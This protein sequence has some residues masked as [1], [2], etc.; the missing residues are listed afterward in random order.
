MAKRSVREGTVFGMRPAVGRWGFVAL[1]LTINLCLG[2]VY[3]F[4]V[5][6]TPLRDL[7]GIS[8]TASG[9]LFMV[10]LAMFAV[11]M[12][13]TGPFLARHG[14]RRVSLVGG[15]LVGLGWLL[16][17]FSP[18]IGVLTLFYGGVAGGG[19]GVLYGCPIATS[20][21]WFPDRRGL[22]VGL[23]VLGF[24]V[25]PLVTAPLLA[26]SIAQLGVLPTFT[27]F[28]ALFLTLLVFLALPLRFPPPGWAP[29]G[30]VPTAKQ[31]ARAG[32]ELDRA[33]IVRTV[34]FYALWGGFTLGSVAGLMA[35]SLSKDFGV[36]V[37]G[38]GAGLA[39]L[40]VSLFAVFNGAGRPAFGWLIDRTTPRFAAAVSFTLILLA[41]AGLYGWGEGSLAV[42]LVAFSV[43]WLNLGGWVAMAP[44]S[45]AALFGPRHYPRNFALVFSG[46]GVG[47]IG[48][49]LLSG[50]IRDATGSYLPVFLPVMGLAALGIA[51]SVLG[52]RPVRPPLSAG[53][54]PGS[55]RAAAR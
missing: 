8:A 49:T 52:L 29:A 38:A 50:A 25:S 11:G 17:G 1:G 30:W 54:A 18:N 10:F 36:E 55:G 15:A 19:V 46:Y 31:R 32:I 53:T 37:A 16:A 35:V 39:T 24:G 5:F 40:A 7:W 9:F 47:A 28:G 12:A 23:T 43:L 51:T 20:T 4:S 2:A 45:T 21:A 14:P 42:Y 27:V 44:A 34:Q 41:A 26:L 13:V 22:A 33:Q 3:A 48:G 6:K